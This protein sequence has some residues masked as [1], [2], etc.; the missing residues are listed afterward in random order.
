MAM[1]GFNMKASN[2]LNKHI[3]RNRGVVL[4]K[5]ILRISQFFPV[6]LKIAGIKNTCWLQTNGAHSNHWHLVNWELI[7]ACVI[8]H[9]ARV[10]YQEPSH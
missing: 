1:L 5:L 2:K 4:D 8:F 7:H 10:D 6:R 3:P 9:H